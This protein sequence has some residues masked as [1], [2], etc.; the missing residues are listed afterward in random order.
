MTRARVADYWSAAR[1]ER[2]YASTTFC[3]PI[4]ILLTRPYKDKN[5]INLKISET[6]AFTTT[7]LCHCDSTTGSSSTHA[8]PYIGRTSQIN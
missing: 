6:H 5:T 2:N 4:G 8:C 7:Q 1:E 3:N